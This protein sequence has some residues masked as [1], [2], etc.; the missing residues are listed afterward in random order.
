MLLHATLGSS[1]W[2]ILELDV[3]GE[4][5]TTLEVRRVCRKSSIENS[6]TKAN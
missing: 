3:H 2:A 5:S 1:S 6:I 4:H